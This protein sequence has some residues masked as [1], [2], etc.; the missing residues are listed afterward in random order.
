MSSDT[1]P[2]PSCT[3]GFG[4]R[5]GFDST[6][7]HVLVLPGLAL[8]LLGHVLPVRS[9]DPVLVLIAQVLLG[10]SFG[11]AL[12]LIAHFSLLRPLGSALVSAA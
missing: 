10:R 11:L 8:V 5:D 6:R 2:P 7:L 9:L 12:V 3:T 1:L 4:P